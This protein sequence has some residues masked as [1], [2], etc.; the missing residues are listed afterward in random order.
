MATRDKTDLDISI[1][2]PC[3]NHGLYLREAVY[4][5]RELAHI[6]FEII[7]VNDGSTDAYTLQVFKELESEGYHVIH[8]PNLG[9]GAARN[10][11]IAHAKGKYILPLDSDNKI[12]PEYI[13]TS[14]SILDNNLSD[15]VY[16][17][18]EFFGEMEPS[19]MFKPGK[20]DIVNMFN[21]NYIDACAVYR[22]S[23]WERN[24]GYETSMPFPGHEDWEFWINAY[25]NEFRFEY[26]DRNLFCYR[27][28]SDSMIVKTKVDNRR[29]LN[30]KFIIKKHLDLYISLYLQLYSFKKRIRLEKKRP[31]R[32]A[33]KYFLIWLKIK[34]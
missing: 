30:Q 24:G 7:V 23:V 16:A 15:I 22:K 18:P 32:S 2:I 27:I 6:Q 28:C 34:E 26:V 21:D 1:I 29:S 33:V 20:F 12:K 19:R 17:N 4:S 5:V 10:T 14:I 25:S 11:G 31:L 8:Q 13:F 9:L 3:Y